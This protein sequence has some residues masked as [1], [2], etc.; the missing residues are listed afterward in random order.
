[1]AS[2]HL[3]QVAVLVAQRP[4]PIASAPIPHGRQ[5]PGKAPLGRELPHPRLTF[6]RLAPHVGKAQKVERGSVRL[7]MA[8]TIR[9][10]VAKID[11]PRLDRVEREPVPAKSLAQHAENP[12]GLLDCRDGQNTVVGIPHEDAV[13]LEAR[14]HVLLE[15]FIQHVM[16]VDV[17]KQGRDGALNAK[18]NSRL[19]AAIS[20]TERVVLRCAAEW[21]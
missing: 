3:G 7:P 16:Q 14:S 5:G 11:E 2:H 20:R 4:M 12:L 8:C 18:G 15:P 19:T 9:A 6:P 13:T 1:M 10:M 17:C 21:L